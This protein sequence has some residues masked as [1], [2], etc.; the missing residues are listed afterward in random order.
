MPTTPVIWQDLTDVNNGLFEFGVQ[1]SPR[2]TELRDGRILV[3]WFD[4]GDNYDNTVN[5]DFVGQFFGMDGTPIGTPFQMNTVYNGGTAANSTEERSHEVVAMSDGGWMIV[6]QDDNLTETFIR[7]ERFDATGTRTDFQ[8][9]ASGSNANG[10]NVSEPSIATNPAGDWVVVFS[11]EDGNGTA[12]EGLVFENNAFYPLDDFGSRSAGNWSSQPINIP[13]DT[14]YL[15]NGNIVTVNHDLNSLSGN[16]RINVQVNTPDGTTITNFFTETPPPLF[17]GV[18]YMESPQVSELP[19]GGFVVTY[20]YQEDGDWGI[21]GAVYANDGS[22]IVAPFFVAQA[23]STT[24]NAYADVVGLHGGG[25]VVA[26]EQDND[27]H[28]RRFDTNGNSV[29]NELVFPDLV[30]AVASHL[31]FDMTLTHDGRIMITWVGDNQPGPIDPTQVG[32]M[33]LDTRNDGIFVIGTSGVDGLTTPVGGGTVNAGDGADNVMGHDGNDIFIDQDLTSGDHYDGRGGIDT[34]NYSGVTFTG[35]TTINLAAGTVINSFGTL[36]DYVENIE[37][38]IGSQGNDTIVAVEGSTDIDGQGG[39]DRIVIQD[40]DIGNFR[41]PVFDGGT[42][43]DTLDLSGMNLPEAL[44][45]YMAEEIWYAGTRLNTILDFENVD[46]SENADYIFGDTGA[47]IIN[48]RGGGDW[49]YGGANSDTINGGAGVDLMFGEAGADIMNGGSDID[50]MWGGAQSDTMHGDDGADWLYGEGGVDFLYGDAGDDVLIGG[51]GNDE[52]W[53][54]IDTDT[55]YGEDD[56]DLIYGEANGDVAFGQL[57][58]DHL[59]GGSEGDFLYGGAGEDIINGGT[60]N[61]LMWGDMPGT[62]DGVKDIFE[63]DANWGFD[64]IYDFE[65]G[66]DVIAFNAIDGLKDF[67]DL[68]LI[69]GGANV[70]VV[71]GSDAITF[72]GVTAAQLDAAQGDFG[73][74]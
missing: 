10:N 30:N 64:A 18:F 20:Q 8:T 14:A 29:G 50:Y 39:N 7:A 23:V 1:N 21:R 66:I 47:N 68:T 54:G 67:S 59:F 43:I 44:S 34:I 13:N 72:Y 24:I 45:V 65:L 4:D 71:Y 3:S 9:V 51:A 36:F 57:G 48:G 55:F 41:R 27:L 26:W 37:N 62:F 56:D 22:T 32:Y 25:F 6:Y 28:V 38:V 5:G 46:G 60:E 69:D 16:N 15:S 63:F 58:D 11:R 35:P 61:D 53:G 49:I 31:S 74:L 19:G 73:F 33:I 52:M 12:T 70:T 17:N 42:G 2:I 40:Y